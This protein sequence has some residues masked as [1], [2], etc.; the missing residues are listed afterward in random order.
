MTIATWLPDPNRYLNVE[1]Y[2]SY[3][4]KVNVLNN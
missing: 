1:G 4:F 2:A 3:V